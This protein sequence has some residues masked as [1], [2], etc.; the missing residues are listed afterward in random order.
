MRPKLVIAILVLALSGANSGAASLCAAY[1]MSSASVGGAALHH[2]QMES[3]RSST[4]MSHRT[5]ARH[6]GAPCAECP[7]EL[8][9]SLNQKAD[10]ARLVQIQALK[11]ASFSFD[12]PRGIAYFDVSDTPADAAALADD[13]PRSLLFDTSRRIGSSSA[14]SVPLRI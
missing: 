14:A 2:Y 8:G 10:C 9:D 7:P 12:A 4:S 11:E 5:H 6:H 3:Q 1:C 13:G